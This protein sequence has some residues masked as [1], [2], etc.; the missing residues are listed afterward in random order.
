MDSKTASG[1]ESRIFKHIALIFTLSAAFVFSSL[2]FGLPSAHA[3]TQLSV[4]EYRALSGVPASSD[5]ADGLLNFTVKSTDESVVSCSVTKPEGYTGS[6]ECFAHARGFGSAKVTASWQVVENVYNK[7]TKKF[8]QKTKSYEKTFE[9]NVQQGK[10]KARYCDHIYAGKKYS[11]SA[12]FKSCAAD[13]DVSYLPNQGDGTFVAGTD[14]SVTNDGK[15][16]KFDKA[17][18][19]I[20]VLY[21]IG[22]T[23]YPI[24]VAVVHSKDSVV[25]KIT[26]I[27][28][29]AAYVPASF[30]IKSV[31]FSEGKVI[32]KFSL[33]NLAGVTKIS[34]ISA[35]FTKGS[36]K[37]E[38]LK[39]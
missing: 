4:G 32:V 34:K 9:F 25:S 31:G 30:R 39:S 12:L 28:K 26:N 35:G 21:Q 24:K 18:S 1:K 19:N 37:Y 36:F 22:A 11:I 7:K 16:V 3:V 17:T 14:Y 2:L 5:Y 38:R 8:K 13:N 15:K 33:V 20:T 23:T 6:R 29:K 27:I 10:I